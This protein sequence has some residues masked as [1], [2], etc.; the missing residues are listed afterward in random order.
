[1]SKLLKNFLADYGYNIVA[2]P[3]TDI[4]PLIL[5]CQDGGSVSSLESGI[6]A[7][8]TSEEQAPPAVTSNTATG[9]IAG[10]TSVSF[11]SDTGI[12]LLSWLLDKLK[13]GKLEAK[14]NLDSNKV[15]TFKYEKVR[16]DKID[17]VKLDGFLTGSTPVKNKFNT[18]RAKLMNSELYV[19]NSVLKSNTFTFTIEDKSGASAD[20]DATIKGIAAI[21]QNIKSTSNNSVT[22]TSRDEEPLVFAFRAQHILYKKAGFWDRL[23]DSADAAGGFTIRNETGIVLKG[24]EDYAS[25]PLQVLSGQSVGL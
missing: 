22:I 21:N 10:S 18:F 25:E 24:P 11:D 17:L 3:R 4:K 13:L 20:I 12:S 7:L 5:L 15:L 6:A 9:D 8:F 23:L 1:M 19:I 16:E 14:A 2:L